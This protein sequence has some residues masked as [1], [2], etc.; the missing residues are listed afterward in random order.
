MRD[1]RRRPKQRVVR[2]DLVDIF[3][4]IGIAALA[5]YSLRFTVARTRR[6]GAAMDVPAQ[7]APATAGAVALQ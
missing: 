1:E 4:G 7:G 6:A 3:G 2:I 5:I